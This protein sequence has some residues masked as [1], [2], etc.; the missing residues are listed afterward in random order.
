MAEEAVDQAI[1]TF[2]LGRTRACYTK[3][4]PLVGAGEPLS[5]ARHELEHSDA[6]LVI[7]DGNPVGVLT[8]VDLLSHLAE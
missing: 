1:K 2:L 5:V 8:R 6:V 4:F 3:R 7:E